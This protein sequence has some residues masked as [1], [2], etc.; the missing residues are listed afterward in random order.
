MLARMIEKEQGV[1]TCLVEKTELDALQNE[2]IR[3]N[4]QIAFYKL[5]AFEL[6]L[7]ENNLACKVILTVCQ[8]VRSLINGI[9]KNLNEGKENT[10]W[11]TE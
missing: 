2:I 10:E 11:K 8:F 9:R 5:A 7:Y 1:E 4:N 6:A 3:L